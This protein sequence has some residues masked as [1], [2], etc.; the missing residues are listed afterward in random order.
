M[1]AWFLLLTKESNSPNSN[2]WRLVVLY[3]HD[4]MKFQ[5]IQCWQ[6]L[7]YYLALYGVLSMTMPTHIFPI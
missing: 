5:G 1:L 3:I 2:Y 4:E 6:E 7:A